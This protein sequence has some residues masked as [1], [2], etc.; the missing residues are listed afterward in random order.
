MN[1]TL[2]L[3]LFLSILRVAGEEIEPDNAKIGNPVTMGNVTGFLKYRGVHSGV[4]VYA[5]SQDMGSSAPSED[6]RL[7]ARNENSLEAVFSLGRGRM[8]GY[9]CMVEGDTMRIFVTKGLD[10]EDISKVPIAVIDLNQLVSKYVE[11][12]A[13]SSRK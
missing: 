3:I 1:K 7:Y 8:E 9:R 11:P 13:P 10:R 2:W 6:F 12:A 5:I 4:T